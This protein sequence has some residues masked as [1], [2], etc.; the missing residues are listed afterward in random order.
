M[1]GRLSKEKNQKELLYAVKRSKYEDKIQIMLTGD[2]P[3]RKA[4]LKLAKRLKFTNPV[5]QKLYKHEELNT[6]LWCG[7]LYVHT[8]IVEIEAISCLEAIACGMVPVIADSKKS[9]T[10]KFALD[11]RCKYQSKNID[12]LTKHIEYW[13]EHREEMDEMRTKYAGFIKQFD[14]VE[15]MDN[16]EKML[17]EVKEKFS[18]KLFV[19]EAD[20]A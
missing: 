7:D 19:N 8:S 16:M 2:G 10:R 1:S 13:Y 5:I 17:V 20:L 4:L 3:R 15:C 12:D 11:D 18:K 14:F 6:A 9:A